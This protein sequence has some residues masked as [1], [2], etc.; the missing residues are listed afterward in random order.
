MEKLIDWLG[1]TYNI[2]HHCPV[3]ISHLSTKLHLHCLKIPVD[4]STHGA[5]GDNNVLNQMEYI[6]PNVQFVRGSPS[7]EGESAMK[8]QV[9]IVVLLICKNGVECFDQAHLRIGIVFV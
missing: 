7:Q 2:A 1:G 8:I 9:N 3:Y 4:R 5:V 6:G